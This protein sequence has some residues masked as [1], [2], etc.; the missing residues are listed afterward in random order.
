MI[1]SIIYYSLAMNTVYII[2]MS[3][4]SSN[5][6][7]FFQVECINITVTTPRQQLCFIL[8]QPQTI[9]IG[10]FHRRFY[11]YCNRPCRF[12]PFSRS[13]RLPVPTSYF[14][15]CTDDEK[16]VCGSQAAYLFARFDCIDLL[17]LVV[18]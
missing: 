16:V 9:N 12:Q 17:W 3:F 4:I 11:R 13:Y 5:Q 15:D 6:P 10:L 7:P 14:I 2:I 8:R 1:I 18:I